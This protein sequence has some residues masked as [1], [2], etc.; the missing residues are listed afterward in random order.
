MLV[1]AGVLLSVQVFTAA[2]V[3]AQLGVGSTGHWAT[4]HALAPVVVLAQRQD[5]NRCSTVC[6]LYACT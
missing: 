6:T 2:A 5:A 3:A 4:V 1:G